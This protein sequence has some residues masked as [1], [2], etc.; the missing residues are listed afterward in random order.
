MLSGSDDIL[1]FPNTRTLILMK[2]RKTVALSETQIRDRRVNSCQ[3]S[4]ENL[5]LKVEAALSHWQ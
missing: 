4:F 2:L 1:L 5:L 3:L